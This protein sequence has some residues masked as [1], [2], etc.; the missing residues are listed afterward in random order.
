[1][2]FHNRPV[3]ITGKRFEVAWVENGEGKKLTFSKQ[4]NAVRFL[5]RLI[6]DYGL[7]NATMKR[8]EN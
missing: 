5:N 2:G 4:D 7:H 1:M 3:L 8:I 6:L